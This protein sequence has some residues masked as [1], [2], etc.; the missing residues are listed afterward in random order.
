M[1]ATALVLGAYDEGRDAADFLV[2]Q[3]LPPGHPAVALAEAVH[4]TRFYPEEALQG[5]LEA[6]PTRQLGREAVRDARMRL[7]RDPRNVLAWADLARGYA[8]LGQDELAGRAMR[9]AL[10]LA[11]ANRWLLR[12]AARLFV[13][14]GEPDMAHDLLSKSS[15][16]KLD[17]WI[18]SAEIATASKAQRK[19]TTA[20]R[21]K[22]LLQGESLGSFQGSELASAI[23]T[24]ELEHGSVRRGKRF[25]RQS[26]VEPTDNAVAQA[27]WATERVGEIAESLPLEVPFSFEARTLRFAEEGKWSD[28]LFESHRWFHDEPFSPKAALFGSWVAETG[29]EDFDEAVTIADA[30]LEFH[31]GDVGLINNLVFALARQGNLERAEREFAVVDILGQPSDMQT[32]LTATQG[33]LLYR[34]GDADGGR[35]L[36]QRAMESARGPYADRVRATAALFM[37]EEELRLQTEEGKKFLE[38]ALAAAASMPYSEIRDIANRLQRF[39]ATG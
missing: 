19:S 37:A 2:A 25:L 3:N 32:V 20:G 33:L 23:G 14:A 18:M 38:A 22:K 10:S 27:E 6:V 1:A 8:I 21:G 39:V 17:P 16:A 24:L 9:R 13:E 36:Y 5:A 11:P 28:A 29:L 4:R 31:P 35:L 26:L 7:E 12:S 34:G 30:G 15:L